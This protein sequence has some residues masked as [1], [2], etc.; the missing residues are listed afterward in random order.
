MI[1]LGETDHYQ[2]TGG[3]FSRLAPLAKAGNVAQ[4]RVQLRDRSSAT[5]SGRVVKRRR[6]RKAPFFLGARAGKNNGGACL[7]VSH[8]CRARNA[9]CL[10]SLFHSNAEY[11]P[12]TIAQRFVPGLERMQRRSLGDYTLYIPDWISI[13]IEFFSGHENLPVLKER[14]QTY[15]SA[16]LLPLLEL[17]SCPF[18]FYIPRLLRSLP[19]IRWDD[20]LCT[21]NGMENPPSQAS[22]DHLTQFRLRGHSAEVLIQY[23]AEYSAY[24]AD[25]TRRAL[26]GR[27]RHRVTRQ[28]DFCWC[29]MSRGYDTRL[30]LSAGQII[31]P[32]PSFFNEKV[33]VMFVVIASHQ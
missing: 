9:K 20:I 26:G 8:G 27:L 21:I 13:V 18:A 25:A 15:P 22:I 19:R 23:L 32:F 24:A 5:E 14:C 11:F 4:R 1:P 28:N 7:L 31:R 12:K 3:S 10:T 16:V 2:D 33:R 29:K 6:Y 17:I 30:T